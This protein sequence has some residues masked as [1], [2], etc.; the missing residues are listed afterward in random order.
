ML[1]VS[2]VGFTKLDVEERSEHDVVYNVMCW[3][4][5]TQSYVQKGSFTTYD[6]AVQFRD[7]QENK[8]CHIEEYYP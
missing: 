4:D 7:S 2:C 6:R 1:I 3:S 8:D 5:N